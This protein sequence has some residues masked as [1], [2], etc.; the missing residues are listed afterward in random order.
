MPEKRSGPRGQKLKQ[1]RQLRQREERARHE[2]AGVKVN[3]PGGENGTAST[4]THHLRDQPLGRTRSQ[5]TPQ[6]R[7]KSKL[8]IEPSQDERRA[9]QSGAILSQPSRLAPAMRARSRQSDAYGARVSQMLPLVPHDSATRLAQ[10]PALIGEVLGPYQAVLGAAFPAYRNHV[11]R[12]VSLCALLAP[13]SDVDRA[14]SCRCCA[15]E[16]GVE[17]RK[18]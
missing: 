17:G 8:S 7:V 10:N 3:G 13:L 2:R 5:R 4:R 18:R 15:G 16:L 12:V 11:C 14:Q 6:P 9:P 1:V